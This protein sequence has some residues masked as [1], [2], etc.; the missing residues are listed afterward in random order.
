M[1]NP[2]LLSSFAILQNLQYVVD[3]ADILT[4]TEHIELES[5]AKEI[6]NTYV[7]DVF[8]MLEYTTTIGH[9]FRKY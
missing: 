6:Y 2:A 7:A 4:K 5:M 1:S 3:N 9:I 8:I